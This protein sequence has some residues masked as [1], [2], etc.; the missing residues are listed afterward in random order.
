MTPVV[1]NQ[2]ASTVTM[3]VYSSSDS[4]SHHDSDYYKDLMNKYKI[5]EQYSKI[6][7]DKDKAKSMYNY[8]K[9]RYEQEKHS[10]KIT[11]R[12]I[13]SFIVITIIAVIVMIATAVS[14]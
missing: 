12:I 5:D 4:S 13:V 7:A 2:T 1:N 10:E 14:Y 9:K 6:K 8:S 11:F 3:P